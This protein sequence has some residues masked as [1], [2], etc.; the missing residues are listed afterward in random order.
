MFELNEKGVVEMELDLPTL[1]KNMFISTC[2]PKPH[3]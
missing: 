1:D 3:F 2:S